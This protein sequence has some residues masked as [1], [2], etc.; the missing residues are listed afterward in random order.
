M[1]NC[2]FDSL[3][4][5]SSK[6]SKLVVNPFLSVIYR[7]LS[8]QIPANSG[9]SM[10]DKQYFDHYAFLLTIVRLAAQLQ[11]MPCDNE[12]ITEI[13]CFPAYPAI[14]LITIPSS[15]FNRFRQFFCSLLN[16]I[17]FFTWNLPKFCRNFVVFCHTSPYNNMVFI[18]Y[19]IFKRRILI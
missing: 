18:K 1:Q 11:R 6:S 8:R 3:S 14:F 19:C 10:A 12:Y 13:H 4:Y 7:G 5:Q 2:C 15:L 17:H 9:S 16:L